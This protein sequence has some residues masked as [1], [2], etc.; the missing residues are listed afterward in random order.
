LF[1]PAFQCVVSGASRACANILKHD[2]C[3]SAIMNRNN[4]NKVQRPAARQ[5][6][7]RGKAAMTATMLL[8]GP[9]AVGPV[10]V[11]FA[12]P[13]P[14]DAPVTP[15]VAPAA[16]AP[17]DIALLRRAL[18]VYRAPVLQIESEF[19]LEV[20]G[21]GLTLQQREQIALVTKRADKKFRS[22]VRMT[23]AGGARYV[24]VSDGKQVLTHRP[25]RS[26]Y[27]VAPRAAWD[28]TD[29]NLPAL[30]LFASA[31]Q[32]GFLADFANALNDPRSSDGKALLEHLQ[33]SG[34]KLTG[35]MEGD[36]Y[37]V[38]MTFPS[39]G[40]GA[41]SDTLRLFLDPASGKCEATANPQPGPQSRGHDN[42]NG[43][44]SVHDA[45]GA[46][47]GHVRDYPTCGRPKGQITF[48][49]AALTSAGGAPCCQKRIIAII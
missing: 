25:G 33:K 28:K 36:Q 11:S 22:T 43:V 16:V 41:K 17:L 7:R 44:T 42:R 40:P 4:S 18:A 29:D 32:D 3:H 19:V 6:V 23:T 35:V 10:G 31:Y 1:L 24:I 48:H 20:K 37:V 45:C 14:A 5:L 46:E 27:A 34:G 21:P 38:S 30:G 9:V 39:S 26:Q 2:I 13:T 8:A 15:N 47:R 12:A 49:R